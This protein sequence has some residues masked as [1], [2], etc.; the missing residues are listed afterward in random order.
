MASCSRVS[1]HEGRSRSPHH[2][3]TSSTLSSRLRNVSPAASAFA[4]AFGD[5]K[6]Q[7]ASTFSLLGERERLAFVGGTQTVFDGYFSFGLDGGGAVD[8]DA[9][10]DVALF[11]KNLVARTVAALQARVRQSND[12]AVAKTF[13][14]L[15]AT[16]KDLAA[17]ADFSTS[18]DRVARAADLTKRSEALQEALAQRFP[19]LA[20]ALVRGAPRTADVRAA[21]RPGEAAVEIVR[22]RHFTAAI[23]ESPQKHIL[24]GLAENLA[25]L[26][27]ISTPD[28]QPMQPKPWRDG[29]SAL[30]R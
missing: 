24:A 18:P 29:S 14:D 26:I 4:D 15:I 30:N 21:L 22:F 17:I 10:Y 28:G 25:V 13:D 5:V 20:E 9:L 3:T 7:Y 16:K 2:A 19:D 23:D 1:H 12:P 6:A 27:T 8:V 11:R